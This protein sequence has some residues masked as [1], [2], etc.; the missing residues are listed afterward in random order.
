MRKLGFKKRQRK[1]VMRTNNTT[2]D[3][4]GFG[5]ALIA[6]S[7]SKDPNTQNGACIMTPDH[8]VI[9]VGYNGFIRNVEDT[10]KR[11]EKPLKYRYVVHAERNA[12]ANA[13]LPSMLKGSTIYIWSSRRY[14]PCA[15]CAKEMA[16]R[17][18]RE[19]RL[20]G[21]PEP[22]AVYDWAESKDILDL[23]GVQITVVPFSEKTFWTDRI[24]PVTQNIPA[25]CL[26]TI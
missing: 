25:T 4:L 22:N 2:W 1:C 5:I 23:A 15:E 20:A 24:E 3:E 9:G 8:I 7:R 10:N 16:H 26:I 12:I 11:W 21:L 17:G 19:I 13:T 14:L 18:I 6:G